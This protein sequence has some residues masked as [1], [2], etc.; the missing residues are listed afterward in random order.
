M[1]PNVFRER[2]AKLRTERGVS[3]RG[4]SLALGKNEN[5]INKIENGKTYPT[6]ILFFEICDFLG[7]SEKDFFDYEIDNPSGLNAL[8]EKSKKLDNDKLQHLSS[9]VSDMTG[10]TE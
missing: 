1:N 8:I 2:L 6:M 9:I 4:M 3:A 7:V 10:T 5:Y